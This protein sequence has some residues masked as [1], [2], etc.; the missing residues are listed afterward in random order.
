MND[1]NPEPGHED[2]NE[3]G[4]RLREHPVSRFDGDHHVFDLNTI[5]TEL[6]NEAHPSTGGH[7]CFGPGGICTQER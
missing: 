4:A 1:T 3:S 2:A 6:Q 7:R 5:A